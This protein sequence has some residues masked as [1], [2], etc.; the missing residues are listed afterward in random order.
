MWRKIKKATET[1]AFKKNINYLFVNAICCF[2][3]F[4]LF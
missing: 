2:D 4:N 3:L 1:V